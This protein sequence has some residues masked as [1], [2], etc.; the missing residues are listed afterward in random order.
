MHKRHKKRLEQKILDLRQNP[1]LV[2][3]FFA[4]VKQFAKRNNKASRSGENH[5]REAFF[6]EFC[7]FLRLKQLQ[8]LAQERQQLFG[9]YF[10]A[11]VAL[12]Q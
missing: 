8:L 9:A 10:A 11:H 4:I 2:I 3:G 7:A 5:E 6:C 1:F 12:F